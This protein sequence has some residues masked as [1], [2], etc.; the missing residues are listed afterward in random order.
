MINGEIINTKCYIKFYKFNKHE[1]NWYL[2]NN[3]M[4]NN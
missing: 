3:I 2:F 4:F 1:N